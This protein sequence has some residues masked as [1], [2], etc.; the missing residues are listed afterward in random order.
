MKIEIM[1]GLV[2][3]NNSVAGGSIVWTFTDLSRMLLLYA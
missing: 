2:E 3:L 1:Q